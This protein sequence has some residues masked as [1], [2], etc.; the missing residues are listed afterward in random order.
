M[1]DPYEILGV[2]RDATPDDIRQAYRRLA[3]KLHPDLNP[4]DKSSEERFKD[5]NSAYQLLSD[6]DQRRRFDAGEIDAAGNERPQQNYYRDYAGSAQAEP[7]ASDAAYADFDDGEDAFAELLRQAARA[8]A[9]RRGHDLRYSLPISLAD[10][11]EGGTRRLTLPGGG[12]LDVAIPAGVVDGQ[13]LRLRGKGA[14][15]AGEGG[16]GDAMIEITVLPDPRFEYDGDDITLELP[17][18]LHEAVLGGRIRVPTPTGA[19]E[20]RVPPGSNTGTTLRLKGKGA[21]RRGGGRGD[22][23]VRLK[24]VLPREVDPELAKFVADWQA[25]KAFDPRAET[26]P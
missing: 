20:M 25:G 18:S 13:V 17:V 14:P 12:T 15:G 9:H 11:I 21:P 6:A 3:R 4:G 16:P 8:R 1:S 23:F 2:A 10:A 7:Y 22:Q 26:T 24:I 5:V 19:V